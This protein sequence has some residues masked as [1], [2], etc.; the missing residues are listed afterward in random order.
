MEKDL[1]IS[2]KWYGLTRLRSD[3]ERVMM[4]NGIWL[5]ANTVLLEIIEV[6]EQLIEINPSNNKE[7]GFVST[8]S[9]VAL[10]HR[11]HPM[12]P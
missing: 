11:G 7:R 8:T 2:H 5:F 4:V 9:I 6:K 12:L 3:V 1:D 10:M